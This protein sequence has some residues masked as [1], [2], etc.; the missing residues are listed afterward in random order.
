MSTTPQTL[1]DE[2]LREF[3][4]LENP[5]KTYCVQFQ[6]T[7][8]FTLPDKTRVTIETRSKNRMHGTSESDIRL[9]LEKDHE[10]AAPL[11]AKRILSLVRD[12]LWEIEPRD[13]SV[14]YG[15][16]PTIEIASSER[17]QEIIEDCLDEKLEVQIPK[18]RNSKPVEESQR[19]GDSSVTD[20]DQ[21]TKLL[22][23]TVLWCCIRRTSD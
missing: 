12:N 10:I 23:T 21:H 17:V 19:E 1:E 4:K 11:N 15:P 9:L 5:L 16:N 22:D 6:F 14:E 18:G 20:E 2:V 3:E 13:V 7:C 8:T